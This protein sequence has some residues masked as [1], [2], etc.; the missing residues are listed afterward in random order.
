[1]ELLMKVKAPHSLRLEVPPQ[2]VLPYLC[3]LLPRADLLHLL[4]DLLGLVNVALSS[5][6]FSLGQ[7]LSDFLIQLMYLLCLQPSTNT[8]T[9]NMSIFAKAKI[10]DSIHMSQEHELN[11]HVL[12][13]CISISVL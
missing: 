13:M 1:M 4:Q 10:K 9:S 7:E 12:K 8:F 6:L 5:E 2:R 11:I 3:I